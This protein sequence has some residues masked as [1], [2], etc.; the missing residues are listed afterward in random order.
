MFDN[1]KNMASMLGQAKDLKK[2]LEAIQEELGRKRVEGEAGAGA[3]RV[4]VNGRFEVLGVHLDK[5]MLQTFITPSEGEA[6]DEDLSMIEDLIAAAMNQAMAKA[7]NLVQS[8]FSDMTG[9][10]NL[11]G[12]DKLMGGG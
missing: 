9:G 5:A 12:M 3:V 2:K 6:S 7:R 8:A 1:L 4:V 10:M 11:P